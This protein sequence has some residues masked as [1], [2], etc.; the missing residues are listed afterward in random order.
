MNRGWMQIQ[1]YL[2]PIPITLGMAYLWQRWSGSTTFAWYV[3]LLAVLY[4]YIVPGIGTNIMKKWR[5][6]G[7]GRVGNYYIH[8][9]FIW[10]AN[11][12][13]AL[14]L[15][16]LG[17]PEGP[18]SYGTILRVLLATGAVHAFKGWVY[19]I[20]LLRYGFTEITSVPRLKGKSPEEIAGHYAPVCF[21]L[22]GLTYGLGALAAYHF[23][24]VQHRADVWSH[25]W[26]WAIGGVAMVA[27]PSLAYGVIERRE[28]VRAKK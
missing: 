11:L 16:F 10:A 18:L 13:P 22:I 4:G 25:V 12:S 9:G 27:V 14:F 26:A 21:F 2:L 3:T 5:F 7:P 19:D 24:V 1:V 28:Q 20:A 8:H 17:T 6:H 23:F 15:C